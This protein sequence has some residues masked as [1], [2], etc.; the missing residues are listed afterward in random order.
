[1]ARSTGHIRMHRVRTRSSAALEG[2]EV[3][4]AWHSTMRPPGPSQEARGQQEQQ[5]TG[6]EQSLSAFKSASITF[7]LWGSG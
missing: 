7:Q 2:A 4:G 6:A 1:M 3:A 5:S